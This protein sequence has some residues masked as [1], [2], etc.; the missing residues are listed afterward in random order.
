M[1][2]IGYKVVGKKLYVARGPNQVIAFEILNVPI[3]QL[4]LALPTD[5]EDRSDFP[6]AFQLFNVCHPDENGK[7]LFGE[8]LGRDRKIREIFIGH[9]DCCDLRQNYEDILTNKD[10]WNVLS[11]S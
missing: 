9:P 3:E 11:D 7:A 4:G 6:E 2:L 8:E 1:N 5:F 10:C